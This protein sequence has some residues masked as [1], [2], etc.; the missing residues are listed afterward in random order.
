MSSKAEVRS[1]LRWHPASGLLPS[2]CARSQ[3]Q[4][5]RRFTLYIDKLFVILQDW[6]RFYATFNP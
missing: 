3:V 6:P 5:A 1:V 4:N 2:Y